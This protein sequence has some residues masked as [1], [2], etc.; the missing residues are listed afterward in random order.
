MHK[1]EL[2]ARL[3]SKVLKIGGAM[4]GNN[5]H[6]WTLGQFAFAKFLIYYLENLHIPSDE[7]YDFWS[8]EPYLPKL[9]VDAFECLRTGAGDVQ[10][11]HYRKMYEE[12]TGHE[13]PNIIDAGESHILHQCSAVQTTLGF[14]L[15]DVLGHSEI[16]HKIDAH[17]NAQQYVLQ[18]MF[19]KFVRQVYRQ[20]MCD[21][22]S[23]SK[24]GGMGGKF[25]ETELRTFVVIGRVMFT[26]ARRIDKTKKGIYRKG[27]SIVLNEKSITFVASEDDLLCWS[28]GIQSVYA[29]FRTAIDLIDDVVT[30]WSQDLKEQK[31]IFREKRSISLG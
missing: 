13:V 5:E 27:E 29:D 17:C 6:G 25:G 20:G 8:I 30:H 4:S 28:A 15:K 26:F 23:K 14:L 7:K 31:K 3:R 22:I 9:M 1:Q 19:G 16:E 24:S 18:Q 2:I 11:A 12:E 21:I 10:V